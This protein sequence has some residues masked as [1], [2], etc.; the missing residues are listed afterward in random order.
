MEYHQALNTTQRKHKELKCK[1]EDKEKTL[2][3]MI[4]IEYVI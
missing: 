3:L 2:V 4:I 1:D